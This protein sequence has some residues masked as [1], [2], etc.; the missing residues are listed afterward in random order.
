MQSQ[1]SDHVNKFDN[2]GDTSNVMDGLI[3]ISRK[4]KGNPL[5]DET[6]TLNTVI[7]LMGAGFDTVSKSLAWLTVYASVFWDA[8]KKMQREIDDFV[9]REKRN[10]RFEF[11]LT[12]YNA[13]FEIL[14]SMF[15]LLWQL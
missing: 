6:R 5:Y 8:Q 15:Q 3:A 1:I 9:S 4:N 7:D 13:E 14:P 12:I 10:P 2:R 11:G